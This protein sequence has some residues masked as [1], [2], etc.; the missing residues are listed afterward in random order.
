[1]TVC[2]AQGQAPEMIAFMIESNAGKL[3]DL[4]SKK[5]VKKRNGRMGRQ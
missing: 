3:D 1:M 4:K 2:C 5:T